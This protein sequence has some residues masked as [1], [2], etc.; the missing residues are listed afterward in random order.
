M[1]DFGGVGFVYLLQT[2]KGLYQ[3]DLYVACRGHPSLDHLNRVP[4]KQ[5]I[6]RHD[7]NE[8]DN[9]QLDIMHYRLHSDMVEQEIRRINNIEPSV[10]RT[11]TELNVLGFMITKCMERGDGFVAGNEF[12]SWKSCFIKLIRHKFDKQHRDYGI[13]HV[14]RLMN[15]ANDFGALYTDLCAIAHRPLTMDH[16]KQVN[17]YA[18][19]F[20][21][22]HFPEIYTQQQDVISAVTR[23]IEDYKPDLPVQ[24][25]ILPVH[26]TRRLLQSAL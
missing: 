1:K 3:L 10:S 8:G 18:M 5:E 2:D 11:L 15:E 24:R 13:Y 4:H 7:R 14:K 17:R 12:N 6:F 23:H 19:T 22:K 26:T 21:Q 20:V 9:Q 16:F 25:P